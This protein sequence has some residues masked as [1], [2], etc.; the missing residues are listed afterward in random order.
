MFHL[1]IFY[2]SLHFSTAKQIQV[3]I[4]ILYIIAHRKG[5]QPQFRVLFQLSIYLFVYHFKLD[6]FT[7]EFF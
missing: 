6:Y 4:S 5:S 3:N 1:L 7:G 2:C